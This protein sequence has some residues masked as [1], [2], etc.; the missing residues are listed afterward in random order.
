MP[1]NSPA[2]L[3]RPDVRALPGTG[4]PR[5]VSLLSA[6]LHLE[7]WRKAYDLATDALLDTQE[8]DA[9]A[10]IEAACELEVV[11]RRLAAAVTRYR[12]AR[13]QDAGRR[14]L[15]SVGGQDAG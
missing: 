2:P 9:E 8:G 1:A 11:R 5:P 7:Y 6:Y 14:W 3:R 10:L 12:R 4:S 15:R 13:R